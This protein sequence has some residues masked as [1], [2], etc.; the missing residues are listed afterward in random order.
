MNTT[1]NNNVTTA[2]RS[3]ASK[4]NGSR[5]FLA[6]LIAL[7]LGGAAHGQA[8]GQA[9]LMVIANGLEPVAPGSTLGFDA[10]TVGETTGVALTV[11]NVGS[12]TLQFLGQP[13]VSG[14]AAGDFEL[15]QLP[16]QV[17]PGGFAVLGINFVPTQ[18]GTR[19]A[20]IT[21][22]TNSASTPNFIFTVAGTGLA[23]PQLLVADGLNAIEDG[24]TLALDEVEV[25]QSTG[26]ALTIRN[27]GGGTL[28]FTALQNVIVVGTDAADFDVALAVP[29]IAPGGFAVLTIGFTPSHAGESTATI[30]IPSNAPD[31]E[32]F[33]FVVK[34]NA[35][36]APTAALSIEW[37]ATPVADGDTLI[38]GDVT[39]D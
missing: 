34:A 36:E 16:P 28:E 21:I 5:R 17:Q 32:N 12:G 35:V 27:V 9:P 6:V 20:T 29:A 33:S 18:A 31:Q 25:G 23:A 11:R 8:L 3:F 1:T 19:T 24:D 2:T 4:I 10:T 26:K 39:E 30:R 13:A 14:L 22:P 7:M 38:F 37:D 15:N